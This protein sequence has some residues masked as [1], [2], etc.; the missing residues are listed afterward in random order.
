MRCCC[1]QVDTPPGRHFRTSSWR[2]PIIAGSE[3]LGRHQRLF[4]QRQNAGGVSHGSATH[5][6]RD[7]N[8]VGWRRAGAIKVVNPIGTFE[9]V[10]E[11]RHFQSRL[12]ATSPEVILYSPREPQSCV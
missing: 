6:R 3:F 9:S 4:R 11:Q 2:L 10:G 8:G 12:L 7:E 1:N 5:P